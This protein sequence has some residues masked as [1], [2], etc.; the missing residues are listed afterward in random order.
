MDFKEKIECRKEYNIKVL[1]MLMEVCENYPELRLGQILANI[2]CINKC[3]M[4]P[5][6]EEPIDMYERFHNAL[7]RLHDLYTEVSIIS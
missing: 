6:H 3:P 1:K 4:D 5:F 2:E 7:A